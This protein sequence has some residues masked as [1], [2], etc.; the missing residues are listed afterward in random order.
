MEKALKEN[1]V[2]YEYVIY[3]DE[4]NPLYHVFHVTIQEPMGQKC[5]DEECEFFRKMMK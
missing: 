5:N 2:N 1:Q 3:G 4:E